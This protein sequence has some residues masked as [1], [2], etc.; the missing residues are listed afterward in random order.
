[1]ELC[2]VI[3][4]FYAAAQMYVRDIDEFIGCNE[5]ERGG[6]RD[7]LRESSRHL[8]QAAFITCEGLFS[9]LPSGFSSSFLYVSSDGRITNE[10][11]AVAS[12]L[13]RTI[14]A[15]KRDSE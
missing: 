1:M 7:H 12:E 4:P 8:V 5:E 9:F 14:L 13:G 15:G 2:Q 3:V 11:R 6:S 10:T